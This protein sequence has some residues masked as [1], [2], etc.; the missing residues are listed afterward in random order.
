MGSCILASLT[1]WHERKNRFQDIHVIKVMAPNGQGI[2]EWQST[3]RKVETEKVWLLYDERGIHLQNSSYPL[4]QASVSPHHPLH[5][6]LSVSAHAP[7]AYESS[8]FK[9]FVW[10][11]QHLLH[12]WVLLNWAVELKETCFSCASHT[13]ACSTVDSCLH[14]G[15]PS[16]V[17]FFPILCGMWDLSSLTKD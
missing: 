7:A 1:V 6:S 9:D 8:Y 12:L 10:W 14:G 17:F 4:L 11:L 2:S 15:S 13:K 3:W 5:L 16:P